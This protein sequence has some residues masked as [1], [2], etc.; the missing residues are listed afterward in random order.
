MV[1]AQNI[2][3]QFGWWA[4]CQIHPEA[5]NNRNRYPDAIALI[6]GLDGG[7]HKSLF[8][9][10]LTASCCQS[11]RILKSLWIDL[12]DNWTTYNEMF[13]IRFVQR[14]RHVK[15]TL[16]SKEELCLHR[17]LEDDLKLFEVMTNLNDNYLH[18]DTS[19][20]ETE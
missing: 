19:K 13:K 11:D 17:N 15:E 7:Y 20:H 10:Q 6:S 3:Y 1:H 2:E 16:E 9:N 5:R 18:L 12:L 14:Y 4:Y 8:Y